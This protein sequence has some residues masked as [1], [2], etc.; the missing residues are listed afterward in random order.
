MGPG[1]VV[2]RSEQLAALEAVAHER[3]TDP[4]IG[5]LL[6][7]LGSTSSDPRGDDSLPGLERDFLR[8]LRREYDKDVLL[9]V[10][11]VASC[12]RDEGL[13]QAAWIE[14]RKRNDFASFAPHL[15]LMLDHAKEKSRLWG[16]GS[17]PYN[18]QL[19][20]HEPGMDERAIATCFDALRPRLSSLVARISARPAPDTSFLDQEYPVEAQDAFGRELRT[21]LGF[22]SDRG[23]LDL[24][25]HPFTTT[26]GADDVRITT[27]YEPRNLLSGLFSTVHETGHALYELGYGD[28][29]RG[30]CLADGASMGI[31]ESQSRLWENVMARSLPFWR[32]RYATLQ[33]RFP[34]QLNGVDLEAFYKA[35]NVVRPSLI[36]VDADEVTYS[37]HV[38]LRFDLERRLFA[39]TLEVADLPHAWREGMKKYLGV[40]PARDS[41]GVLQD[42]HWSM[43]A[44]GYFPSYALGNIYGLQFW[45]ALRRDLPRIDESIEAG[46]FTDLLAWFREKVHSKGRRS[47]P[48]EL[49]EATTGE[50]LSADA[51]IEYLERKYADAYSL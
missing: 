37:L 39:G 44:F 27:R 16:F 45:R 12:A 10:E 23:R 40:E 17:S 21:D 4:R 2:E 28:D 3:A 13:S 22:Q 50:T 19:D 31:H 35:V 30:S 7:R 38:I 5:E 51:F 11:F 26:L 36:R 43:G 41:D 24:S 18:G 33:A 46:R 14:A 47:D 34:K 25:A 8:V 49:L 1:A 9:P 32:G 48:A 6:E 29:L 20:L 42:I 15:S